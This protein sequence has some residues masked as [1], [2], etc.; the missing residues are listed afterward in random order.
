MLHD[1]ANVPTIFHQL[2]RPTATDIGKSVPESGGSHDY[3]VPYKVCLT[4]IDRSV[5]S[6]Q[7][8]TSS[9]ACKRCR[10]NRS[11]TPVAG[12]KR[13]TRCPEGKTNQ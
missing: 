12:E 8:G 4:L 6:W 10:L 13:F 9:P 3:K 1:Q 7:V 11:R 2:F 5:E